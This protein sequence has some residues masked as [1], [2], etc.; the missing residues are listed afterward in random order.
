M[1]TQECRFKAQEWASRTQEF[2]INHMKKRTMKVR[3]ILEKY[4]K[5]K[6]Q[7]RMYIIT[8]LYH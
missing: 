7:N 1:S 8:R 2:N 4:Q 3:M 6:Y 5:N